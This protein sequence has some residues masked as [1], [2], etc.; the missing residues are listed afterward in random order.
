MTQSFERK[1]IRVGAAQFDAVGGNIA[2]NAAAHE[3]LIA[4]AGGLG[5]DVLVFPELSL[6]GYASNILNEAPESC[7][8]DPG[9][10]ALKPVRDACHRNGVVAVAGG[11]LRNTRGLGLSAIVVDRQG[12][13]CATYDKQYLD[14]PEKDWFVPGASGCMIEVDG[15]RLGV[16]ICYDSSFPEHGRALALEGADAYLVSGAFPLGI[17]DHRRS[18][19]FPARALENTFY[20]AFANFIAGHDGLN[21]CGRS[22]VHG[23]DGRLLADAGPDQT[24]I[25]V[26]ELDSERLLQTRETMAMLRD[27]SEDHAPIQLSTAQ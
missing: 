16:G 24:G 21:Y 5:V 15:W 13:I 17:S 12:R 1:A 27:R 18:I 19:Y 11:S 14:G 9:G 3:R 6:T 26:A 10:P 7:V 25:A 22:S 2:A 4:E 20:V 8:V 23:P